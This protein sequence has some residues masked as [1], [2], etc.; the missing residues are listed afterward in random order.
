MRRRGYHIGLSPPKLSFNNY[1][2]QRGNFMLHLI[3]F[4]HTDVTIQF[5]RLLIYRPV[6]KE[7]IKTKGS[8]LARDMVI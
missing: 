6:I 4:F 8:Y 3:Q 1:K 7:Y 2:F 5:L